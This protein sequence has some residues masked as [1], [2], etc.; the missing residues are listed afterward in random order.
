MQLL[1]GALKLDPDETRH[2]G[3]G[4]HLARVIESESLEALALTG[5]FYALTGVFDLLLAATVLRGDRPR[6]AAVAA[7]GVDRM[8]C[9][10]LAVIYFR[11]RSAGPRCGFS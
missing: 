9:A 4:Q 8:P 5:G 6:A 3:I 10:V 2:Q 11:R 7:G 1:A